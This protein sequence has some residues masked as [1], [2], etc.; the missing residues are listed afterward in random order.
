VPKLYAVFSKAGDDNPPYF[1]VMEFIEGTTILTDTWVKFS[2]AQRE[3]ITSGI[4]EQLQLL[5][6]IPSEGYY[7][8]VKGSIF[9]R[10]S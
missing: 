10:V 9:W 1:L 8:R 6:D 5:R 4:T 3:N 7:R 2:D